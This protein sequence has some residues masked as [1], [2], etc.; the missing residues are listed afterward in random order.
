MRFAAKTTSRPHREAVVP[1][2][3]VVLLLLIFFMMM[4]VVAPPAPLDV[5][6]PGA[7]S[8]PEQAG[9]VQ[10]L[11]IGRDGAMAFGDESGPAAI[12]AAAA[13][14]S[15]LDIRADRDLDAAILAR[16]LGALEAAGAG[17]TRLI[18]VRQ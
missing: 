8:G 18:T 2:I 15:P 3:N 4:A 7:L 6:P 14:P 13:A 11:H 16:V 1:L 17:E 12:E 5:V 10:A 9:Q